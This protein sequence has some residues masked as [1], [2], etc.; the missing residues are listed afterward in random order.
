V[1]VDVGKVVE[2][3]SVVGTAGMIAG[4]GAGDACRDG[5]LLRNGRLHAMLTVKITLIRKKSFLD[6]STSPLVIEL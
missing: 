6:M 4:L 2:L 3:L 1:F 5:E